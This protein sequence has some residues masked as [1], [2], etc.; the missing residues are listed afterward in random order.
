[1]IT[2]RIPTLIAI[3]LTGFLATSAFGQST[4]TGSGTVTYGPSEPEVREL[5]DGR[6]L[7]RVPF[8]GIILSDDGTG[9]FHLSSQDCQGTVILAADG[10]QEIGRG[11][12]DAVDADGDVWWLSWMNR[13]DERSCQILGGTGKFVG[14]EGGGTTTELLPQLPDG[15]QTISWEGSWQMP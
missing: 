1:M 4:M 11:Y 9:P 13:G 12:C 10:S 7:L 3:S 15:R 6:T 5:P 8:K 14:L 2:A